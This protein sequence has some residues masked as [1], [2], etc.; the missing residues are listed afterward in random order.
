MSRN[1]ACSYHRVGAEQHPPR[2]SDTHNIVASFVK[3]GV[4]SHGSLH[5]FHQEEIRSYLA[6]SFFRLDRTLAFSEGGLFG[7]IFFF[8]L[9]LRF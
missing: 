5:G 4:P 1:K 2:E 3:H 8:S 7:F 6:F 9:F